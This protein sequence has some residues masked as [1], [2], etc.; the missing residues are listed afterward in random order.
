MTKLF[1]ASKNYSYENTNGKF[2]KKIPVARREG[3]KERKGTRQ[4]NQKT[5]F[6]V[7]GKLYLISFH[8]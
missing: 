4:E 3:G 7:K 5:K 1:F 2:I 8:K 6:K